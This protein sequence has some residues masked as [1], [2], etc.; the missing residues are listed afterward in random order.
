MLRLFAFKQSSQTLAY[1]HPGGH[2]I[3]TIPWFPRSSCS[4]LLTEKA[5]LPACALEMVTVQKL[6]E[7]FC[8]GQIPLKAKQ[9]KEVRLILHYLSSSGNGCKGAFTTKQDQDVRLKTE[10]FHLKLY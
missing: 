7:L 1:V 2:E 10:R 8:P 4:G 3:W 5:P 9:L 6:C